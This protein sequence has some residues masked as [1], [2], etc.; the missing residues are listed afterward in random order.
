M[1]FGEISNFGDSVKIVKEVEIS[2]VDYARGAKVSPQDLQDSD[3]TL[4]VDRAKAWAFKV[5]DIETS[6]SHINW[7]SMARDRAAYELADNFDQDILGYMS[8]YELV[9]GVWTARTTAVGTVA[10]STADSDELLAANKLTKSAFS[11]SGTGTN[12]IPVGVQGTYDVTPLQVLNRFSRLL[13]QNNV[14]KADRWV[15]V[16]PVFMEL[17]SDENSKLVSNDYAANQ[18][19]GGILRNGRVGTGMIR[20]FEVYESNNLPTFGTGADTVSTAGSSSNYGIVMAGHKSGTATAE[21]LAKTEKIRSS[22]TFGDIVRGMH[23]YGRKI[24]RP[25]V[26]LRAAWNVS[27]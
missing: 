18:N 6:Q 25:E 17:L 3:F 20:G 23:L 9:N 15:I 13:D 16:D 24:L 10:V 21:Q 12:S 4:T 1:Y 22:D 27:R 2:V 19:A 14:P 7:E 5:D 26:L 11:S 8:G